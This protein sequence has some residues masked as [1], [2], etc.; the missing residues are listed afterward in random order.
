M[1]DARLALQGA[2]RA[3]EPDAN[4]VSR[5]RCHAE[6]MDAERRAHSYWW[7]C[8]GGG[9]DAAAQLLALPPRVFGRHAP[10]AMALLCASVAAALLLG[11]G[12]LDQPGPSGSGGP[13]AGSEAAD[14]APL[15]QVAAVAAAAAVSWTERAWSYATEGGSGDDDYEDRPGLR[16]M[17]QWLRE[18]AAS[19]WQNVEDSDE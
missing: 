13:E 12:A 18:G 8:V 4:V 1:G 5:L 14:A 11:G 19:L 6:R 15:Q 16:G 3:L 10:T 17:L 9:T 7:A 2:M